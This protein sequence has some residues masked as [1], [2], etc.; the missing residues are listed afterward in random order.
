MLK[1]EKLIVV[2]ITLL[3]G[4]AAA[5]PVIAADDYLSALEAE[6][7][8]TGSLTTKNVVNAGSDTGL[9]KP[10]NLVDSAVIRQGL[11]FGNFEEELVTHYSGTWVL[12]V[13]LPAAQ[14]RA[15]YKVYRSNNSIAAVR[16]EVV[17]QFASN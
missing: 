2:T 13:K 15:V 3:A 8:D 12:Y 9:Q 6:A 7:N 10:P 5:F 17:R 4:F 16:E 1:P 11:D 14:R